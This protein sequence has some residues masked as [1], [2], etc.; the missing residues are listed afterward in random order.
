M[1]GRD[2]LRV[3]SVL[4]AGATEEEWRTAVSRAYYAAFHVARLLLLDS[5]FRV[6]QADRAHAYLWL[7]L[8]N[9]GDAVVAGAGADLTSLRRQRNWADYDVDRPYNQA[10]A[11]TQVQVARDVIQVF[12]AARKEPTRTQVIETMKVYE[13]D[14]L[15][16]VTW[17]P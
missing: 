2:F 8:S 16:E 5:G 12:D 1:K 17:H 7:R 4:V 13:R 11:V 10:T 6:P 9:C 15:Q 14:V 3:A